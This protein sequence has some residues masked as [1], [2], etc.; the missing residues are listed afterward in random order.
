LVTYIYTYH[1]IA[2][3]KIKRRKKLLNK[4]SKIA[5]I[6]VIVLTVPMIL[7]MSQTTAQTETYVTTYL[8]VYAS[9]NPVGVGQTVYISLF[10][11]KPLP[12]AYGVIWGGGVYHDLTVNIVPPEGANTTLTFEETDM[13]GGVGGVQ[14]VPAVVGNYTVQAFYP[15]ELLAG[16]TDMF[17]KA[18]V[19]PPVTFVV[20]E[21][22]I[23]T[24]STPPLPT[25]YWS[26]PIY[27]TNYA[28]AELGGNWWGH[29]KPAFMNTGGYDASGNNFN[30][31]SQAPNTAHIMWTKPLSFGG[32]PGAPVSSDQE[33]QY[34]STSILYHQLEPIILNGILYYDHYPNVP[35]VR[36]GRVAIDIRTGETL[37]TSDATDTL[38]FGQVL[39][40]HTIQEYGSQAWL[41]A[42]AGYGAWLGFTWEK[43]MFKLYDP[44][45][46]TFVANVTN[47]PSSLVGLFG[48]SPSGLV[49]FSDELTQGSVLMHWIDGNN[50][51]MWNSTLMFIPDPTNVM[52]ASTIR[53]SGNI[54]FTLGIQWSVPI[55]TTIGEETIDPPL[56]MGMN[57]KTDE[58]ILLTSYEAVIPTF[59]TAF[60]EEYATDVAF[61]TKTGEKLWGPVKRKLVKFNEVG[62]IAAGEGYYVRHDKDLNQAYGYS[63]L[64]GEELWGPVQLEGN[65]LSALAR[66]GAIAYGKVYIWD[67]GGYVNAIDLETGEIEWTFTRGS[68]GYEN[69]YGIY[70]I[71]HYGS[72]S[73]A[74]GKLFLSESRMYDPP[75]FPNAHRLAINCTDGSLVW[76]ALGF[77]GRNTGA[78]ADG[79][80]LSYNSYDCQIYTFGKGQTATTVSIQDDV[81]THGDSVLV[82]GMVTDESPGT[83]D[84]DRTARFPHGVPAVSDEC[85]SPWMEYVYMQQ[86]KPTNATG[87]KV[88]LH[89][90]DPNTN[91]YDVATTTSDENGFYSAV[92]TPEVPGK[93]TV[94]ATFEGSESYWPSSAVTAIN[95]EEAP[96]PTPEPTPTPAP[97]TDTYV[98]GIG[99]AAIIAIVVIGLVIILMLRKR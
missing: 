5:L 98:L 97:M 70:P 87:V 57:P 40:F 83:K 51:V 62:V 71:W 11:T 74:D 6:L 55:P 34:T 84:S 3:H 79:F 41:W 36:P 25:E 48:S 10:F 53:P 33:S 38:A 32:Q 93:Y 52:T 99:T 92:F 89:V 43:Y 50:L 78:I 82:K 67:F 75:L 64:T 30:A 59:S 28:W 63:L 14:F 94:Y 7:Q 23:P 81:I 8:K 15:G 42:M 49:D 24:Y 17:L 47:L 19:S 20:Q 69:P 18:A 77:Y 12:E 37:W 31:Y 91:C 35:D 21:E 68:A 13:T 56:S 1:T 39:K 26:R 16:T 76:S 86:P 58:A 54:D 85:M 29:G 2:F 80:L 88:V 72:H 96:V 61:D 27:A 45:T 9:P 4:K 90:F 60:G 65:T 46:G 44:M 22:Q 95:V 73:I 66:G